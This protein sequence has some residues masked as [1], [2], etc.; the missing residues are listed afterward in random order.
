MAAKLEKVGHFENGTRWWRQFHRLANIQVRYFSRLALSL[1]SP[2]C[3]LY[4]NELSDI[5]YK[6]TELENGAK[7]FDEIGTYLY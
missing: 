6:K 2:R 7:E 4:L 3:I 5:V 1:A